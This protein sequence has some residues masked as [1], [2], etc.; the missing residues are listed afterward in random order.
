MALPAIF[1][2]QCDTLV[3]DAI[4][5]PACHWRRPVAVGEVGKPIW[6]VALEVKL[7]SKGSHR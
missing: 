5:C 2:P 7:P 6:A 3:L 4:L 1:C